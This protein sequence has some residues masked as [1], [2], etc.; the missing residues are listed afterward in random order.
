MDSDQTKTALA[1]ASR[2]Y[3]KDRPVLSS[4]RAPHRNNTVTVEQ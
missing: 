3:I 2:I 4:E 1:R